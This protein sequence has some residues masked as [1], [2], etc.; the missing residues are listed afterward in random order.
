MTNQVVTGRGVN[1]IY[2]TTVFG[3]I[4]N[5][6]EIMETIAKIDTTS[7]NNVGA[8]KSYRP[9]FSEIAEL[10]IDVG[11][12]GATEQA[13]IAT[14]KAAGTISTWQIVAPCASVTYA[15]SFQGYVSACSTPTFDKDGNAKMSFKVQPSGTITPISTAVAVGVTDI[16]ITDANTTALT[17][18][19]VFAATTYGYQITT[20]LA[21]TG[22]KFCISGTGTGESVYVNN[23]LATAGTTG[24]AITIPTAAGK[25]LMIPV[26]K[27][28]TACVPKV[29]WI[30]VTHGYV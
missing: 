8:V 14:M 6:S 13:A 30:E 27:F 3:E 24:D 25:V 12:T 20:D 15:W 2:G 5:V 23:V 29:Y 22:V 1:L 4:Q 9:G 26:V 17:L 28:C 18:S 7:H 16:A 10:S 11:F 21:D 19:P